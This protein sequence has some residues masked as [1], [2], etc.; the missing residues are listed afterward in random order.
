MAFRRGTAVVAAYDL[1]CGNN[2]NET[3]ALLGLDYSG[4][5]G[6]SGA[7][8]LP[9]GGQYTFYNP[10][11]ASLYMWRTMGRSNYNALQLDL[12]H[13]MTHGYQFGFT[14]TFSKSIDL[15]SDAERVGTIGGTGSQIQNAWTPYQFRGLS[16]F[17]ATH[18]IT[19]NWVVNLPFGR[20]AAIAHDV[21]RFVNAFIGGWQFSGLG[22]WGSTTSVSALVA[23]MASRRALGEVHR[24]RNGTVGPVGN[25]F[26]LR[27]SGWPGQEGYHPLLMTRLLLY[28]YCVGVASSRAL[29]RK[30]YEDVA[31]RY[32]TADQHPDHDTIANFRNNIWPRWEDCLCRPCNCAKRPDW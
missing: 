28:G 7:S 3:T 31:F 29:E 25:L 12:K 2:L 26:C 9:V 27:S 15:S 16:D 30:S 22:R 23:T 21:N 32:L 8:Y 5:S 20:G 19:A 10:E 4:L 1:F 6:V 24:R 13:R 17:D 14:Y 18:Q 11:Y